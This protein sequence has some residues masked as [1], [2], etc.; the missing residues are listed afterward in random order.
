MLRFTFNDFCIF[1]SVLLHLQ[2]SHLH[3]FFPNKKSHGTGSL[4]ENAESKNF[5][6]TAV[7]SKSLLHIYLSSTSKKGHATKY[8]LQLLTRAV[9]QEKTHAWMHA[10]ATITALSWMDT[11]GSRIIIIHFSSL[12]KLFFLLSGDALTNFFTKLA[13]VTLKP[14]DI[15][16]NFGYIHTVSKIGP[17][18]FFL[19][20]SDFF[21]LQSERDKSDFNL[22]PPRSFHMCY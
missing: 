15:T 14:K 8:G 16:E 19:P 20:K 3:T 1:L 9:R 18:P 13:L 6:L 10:P 4:K 7:P 17:N 2:N 22:I 12:I 21:L 5:F 11:T